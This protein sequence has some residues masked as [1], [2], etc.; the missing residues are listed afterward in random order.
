MPTNVR[1]AP[2]KAA[3]CAAFPGQGG[4]GVQR[5]LPVYRRLR[6]C[7]R[8]QRRWWQCRWQSTV[9]SGRPLLPVQIDG[10]GV[11]V[12]DRLCVHEV[13]TPSSDINNPSYERNG[14]AASVWDP[15][16]CSRG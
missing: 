14:A 15:G 13:D 5:R 7:L 8:Q 6:Q 4:G 12:K 1:R 2:G 11:T 9:A 10:E 3:T 16:K